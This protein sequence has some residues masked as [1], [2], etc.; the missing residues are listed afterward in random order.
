M[1]CKPNELAVIDI[2]DSMSPPHI[3]EQMNGLI[4]KTVRVSADDSKRWDIAPHPTV[5]I[6]SP[7]CDKSGRTISPGTYSA[8]CIED[9]CLRPIRPGTVGDQTRTVKELELQ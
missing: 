9:S 1:N 3:R 6:R 7:I 5:V 2:P 4:V 8:T